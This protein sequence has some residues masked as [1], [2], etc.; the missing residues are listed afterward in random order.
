[1]RHFSFL[2]KASKNKKHRHNPHLVSFQIRTGGRGGGVVDGRTVTQSKRIGMKDLR[3]SIR[4]KGF[5]CQERQKA[6]KAI[7]YTPETQKRVLGQILSIFPKW[8]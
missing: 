8:K 6:Q 7:S 5:S 3:S 4:S 2:Q 1:M